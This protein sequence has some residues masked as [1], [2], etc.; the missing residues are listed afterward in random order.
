MSAV[1]VVNRTGLVVLL[2][3]VVAVGPFARVLLIKQV[4]LAVAFRASRGGLYS[5]C[6]GHFA[7]LLWVGLC[8]WPRQRA[9][10]A[11]TGSGR[12]TPGSSFGLSV[13]GVKP[14]LSGCRQ[15]LE[16]CVEDRYGADVGH[17]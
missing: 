1:P 14:G 3:A 9:L 5:Q 4:E 10:D 6:C 12:L 15:L 11:R 2:F 16:E 7:F 13:P 17:V 8:E